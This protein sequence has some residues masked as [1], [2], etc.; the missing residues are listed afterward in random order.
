MWRGEDEQMWR[1]Q[2]VKM[3]ECEDVRMWRCEDVKVRRCEDEQMWRW[4]DVKMRTCEDEKMWR[5]ADVRMRGCEDVK[6]RRCEDVRMWR[7]EDLKMCGCEDVRMWAWWAWEDVKISRYYVKMWRCENVWQ[8]PT[9][10][11]TLRS[12]ALGKN[13]KRK[14][15][16]WFFYLVR[17]SSL[18]CGAPS[19]GTSHLDVHPSKYG[20][21][22]YIYIY[23]CLRVGFKK[24]IDIMH[25][26]NYF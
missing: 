24:F 13:A 26:I 9:I 22:F 4:E 21:C 17:P 7:W 23:F 14:T 10:R 3:W 25:I 1:W 2:D 5:W 15:L 8:T 20:T 12:D 6:L 19:H 16:H 11:R 18:H